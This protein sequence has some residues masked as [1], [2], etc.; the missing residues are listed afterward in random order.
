[1]EQ[2]SVRLM[3]GAENLLA[4]SGELA[5]ESNDVVGT[6][7]I[8]TGGRLV[9]EEEEFW[10]GCKLD[11]DGK[12]LASFDGET[13]TIGQLCTSRGPTQGIRPFHPPSPEARVAR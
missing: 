11:T 1:M 4:S 7:A 5:E 9:Q 6:L 10:L 12:T 13:E 3:N 8:E 2:K